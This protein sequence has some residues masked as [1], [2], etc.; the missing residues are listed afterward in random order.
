MH[1][2][3]SCYGSVE[4][5]FLSSYH[6]L[7]SMVIVGR[8]SVLRQLLLLTAF[9][10]SCLLRSRSCLGICLISRVRWMHWQPSFRLSGPRHVSA[11]QPARVGTV[12]K[13]WLIYSTEAF[14][15]TPPSP[16]TACLHH[17][18]AI[19]VSTSSGVH[20]GSPR[21]SRCRRDLQSETL[22][23]SFRLLHLSCSQD[24]ITGSAAREAGNHVVVVPSRGSNLSREVA[25]LRF[26]RPHP[27]G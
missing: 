11:H 25:A 5:C 9:R 23:N 24:G 15:G 21:T 19:K 12:R 27:V 17:N 10:E 22:R 14:R 13:T 6:H 16:D 26:A 20:L 4:L 18:T 1:Q 2:R 8:Q 3:I 7:L